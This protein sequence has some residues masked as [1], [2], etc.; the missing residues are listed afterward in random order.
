VGLE[1]HQHL[2][3]VLQVVRVVDKMLVVLVVQV[4]LTQ[5]VMAAHKTQRAVQERI[6][7]L[8]VQR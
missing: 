4:Q 3:Q 2:A 7:A 6:T 1:T 8:Q 5:V